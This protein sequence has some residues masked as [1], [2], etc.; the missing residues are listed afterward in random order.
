MGWDDL[1][2]NTGASTVAL[3]AADAFGPSIQ[4]VSG[5]AEPNLGGDVVSIDFDEPIDPATGFNLA[6][7]TVLNGGVAQDLSAATTRYVSASNRLEIHLA[8]G[9]ELNPAQPLVVQAQNI[10]DF[11]GLVMNPPANLGGGIA[12]DT[13]AP[14]GATAFVNRREDAGSL[15][16]DVLF[17]E[18]VVQ[19]FASVPSNWSTTGAATITAVDVLSPSYYRLTL[20]TPLMAG[21]MV[22]INGISDVAGNVAAMFA[23][24]PTL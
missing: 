22:E 9:V 1:A 12:G 16:V 6:N 11:S 5:L 24:S 3:A 15:V 13:T 2:G 21:E 18:D 8:P 20:S 17:D 10:E 19:A 7:Y 23:F 14:A 4:S